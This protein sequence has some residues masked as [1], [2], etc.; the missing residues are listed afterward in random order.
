VL[1]LPTVELLQQL[2]SGVPYIPCFLLVHQRADLGCIIVEVP[3]GHIDQLL[4]RFPQVFERAVDLIV[5]VVVISRVL[6]QLAPSLE[7]SQHKSL[8]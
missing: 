5:R 3:P 4:L 8:L 1:L 6:Y 7:F 2:P